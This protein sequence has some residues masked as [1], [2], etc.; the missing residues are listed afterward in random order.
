MDVGMFYCPY[1]PFSNLSEQQKLNY[2]RRMFEQ[3]YQEAK[4]N[5]WCLKLFESRVKNGVSITLQNL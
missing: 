5:G 4:N 2:D 3:K 1:N